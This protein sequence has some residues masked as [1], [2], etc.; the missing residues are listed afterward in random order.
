MAWGALLGLVNGLLIAALDILPFIA[1]LAM[2]SLAQGMSL[3]IGG[4]TMVMLT[5][6]PILAVGQG[7]IGGVLPYP[8]WCCW[9]SA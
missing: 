3:M 7:K 5:D 4:G 8:L 2:M 6:S 1:T 9:P